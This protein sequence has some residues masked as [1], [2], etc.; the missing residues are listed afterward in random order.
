MTPE[1]RRRFAERFA[2]RGGEGA[3]PS[4]VRSAGSDDVDLAGDP[5]AGDSIATLP[6]TGDGPRTGP[7]PTIRPAPGDPAA[8]ARTAERAVAERRIPGRYHDLIRR[9]FDRLRTTEGGGSP[10]SPPS[11]PSA[12]GDG[13]GR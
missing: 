6:G 8:A 2:D 7:S 12:D 13:S 10:S 11:T 4:P 1:E 9:Y 3:P 5:D